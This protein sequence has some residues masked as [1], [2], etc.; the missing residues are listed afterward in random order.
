MIT[1][2]AK[3]LLSI[4]VALVEGIFWVRITIVTVSCHTDILLSSTDIALICGH[5]HESLGA[6]IHTIGHIFRAKRE[7][8]E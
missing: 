8:E 6:G 3:L 5:N 1:L 7:V 2:L 4:M